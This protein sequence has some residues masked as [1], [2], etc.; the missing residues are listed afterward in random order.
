VEV[1]VGQIIECSI[2]GKIQLDM[3]ADDG[4]HLNAI[5]LDDVMYVPGLSRR[6][7]S[8]TKFAKHGHFATI[9][10]NCMMLYFGSQHVPVTL[11]AHD[12]KTLAADIQVTEINETPNGT[13]PTI[14]YPG[15]AVTIT[16]VVTNAVYPM[17]Y[18]TVA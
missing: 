17:N 11:P 8:I 9:K 4:S 12:G 7:F 2:A 16:P 15:V 18:Y 10:Q 14:W 5:L 1:A 6:L 13:I 3:L